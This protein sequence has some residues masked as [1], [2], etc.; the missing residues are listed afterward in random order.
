MRQY[1]DN[2]GDLWEE[3]PD[4]RAR[5]VQST[6]AGFV[7]KELP[8][9]EAVDQYGPFRLAALGSPA[10]DIDE[11]DD[12]DLPTVSEVMSRADIF[13]SAHALVSGLK[14]DEAAS[15]YDVL[16]VAKWLEGEG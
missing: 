8:F 10:P 2:M 16:S 3:L 12:V 4:S 14:W 5:C 15:V 13:Q 6:V 1:L 11:P 9:D 7:G